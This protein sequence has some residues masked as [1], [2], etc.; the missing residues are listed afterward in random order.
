MPA[1]YIV[2][3]QQLQPQQIVRR[4]WLDA[5]AHNLLYDV[6]LDVYEK[7]M[8]SARLVDIFAEVGGGGRGIRTSSLINYGGAGRCR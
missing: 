4:Y 3:K 2:S 7:G 8:L 5:Q 6:L 1:D